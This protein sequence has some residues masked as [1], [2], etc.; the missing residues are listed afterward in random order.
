MSNI[1]EL[2][3]FNFPNNK[4]EQRIVFNKAKAFPSPIADEALIGLT[5]KFVSAFE[6]YT[7]ADQHALLIQFLVAFANVVGRSP[8]IAIG[9]SKQHLNLFTCVVGNSSTARKG[10]SWDCVGM[11]F[12][13]VDPKWWDDKRV[14]GLGSG[15]GLIASVKDHEITD[16]MNIDY[17][18]INDKRALVIESELASMINS[19]RREGSTLSANFR[20]AWDS[21]DLRITTKKD[22]IRSTNAHISMIG[23]CTGTE[24]QR[25]ITDIDINNGLANR[26]IWVCAKRSKLLALPKEPNAVEIATLVESLKQA[27]EFGAKQTK[28][29]MN[30]ES[31]Q[32]YTELYPTL[33]RERPGIQGVLSARAAPIILRLSGI[34][35]IL[36]KSA[37]I[38]PQHLKAAVGVWEYSEKSIQY[39]FGEKTG[40]KLSDRLFV[41]LQNKPGGL[42]QTEISRDVF[43]A[44]ASSEKIAEAIEYLSNQNIIR[45]VEETSDAGRKVIRWRLAST[46][47]E[48]NEFNELTEFVNSSNSYNSYFVPVKNEGEEYVS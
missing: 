21:G 47:Y 4:D 12:K 38:K 30:E 43:R 29:T 16:I 39:I 17:E 35:A 3:D 46:N 22:S 2:T 1:D 7:E 20:N 37:E 10:T 5:G 27:K 13:A 19:M 26:F 36:D 6:P 48:M 33:V 41:A 15:E 45:S 28:L 44:N 23:H 18:S 24:L 34:Y 9:A 31:E 8:Y 14:F 40:N 32:L 11:V 25:L 42:T